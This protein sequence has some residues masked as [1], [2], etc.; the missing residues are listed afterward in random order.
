M[1]ARTYKIESK[2]LCIRCYAPTDATLLKTAIDESLE[3]LLPWMPWAQN[4]PEPL[5]AKA[6]RLRKY[7][8]QFDLG[9]DY[10]FGIFSKDQ[11]M[12]IG[13]TG[14]HTRLTGNA[15]EI[16]N[17]IHARYLRQGY[18]TEAVAALVQV[19]FEVEQL[20]R[21]EIRCDPQ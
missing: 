19:G 4:E 10:T 6:D 1:L 14:L 9:V 18:A 17:W 20:E 7:R 8:G 12:L 5:Q 21:I 2:R 11:Q 3:H 16:G 15:R 13:S